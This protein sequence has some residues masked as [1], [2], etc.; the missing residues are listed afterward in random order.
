M[1][2]FVLEEL[3]LI[4]LGVHPILMMNMRPLL[5][6]QAQ[7][8]DLVMKIIMVDLMRLSL[9]AEG[10]EVEMIQI[11]NQMKI[12]FIILEKLLAQQFPRKLLVEGIDLKVIP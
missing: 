6:Y 3:R 7:G 1:R 5:R 9:L 2:V 10:L 12:N 11:T 8:L 4:K